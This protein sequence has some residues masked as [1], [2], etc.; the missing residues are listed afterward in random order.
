MYREKTIGIAIPAYQ[1]ENMIFKTLTGIPQ[2][3][4]KI[5]IVDDGSTDKTS[6]EVLRFKKKLGDNRI[7][8]IRNIT[9]RGNG[10]SVVRG[11]KK[12]IR[13]NLD[14]AMIMAGDNQ[15]NPQFITSLLDPV[16]DGECD[17]AK[18]N[19]FIHKKELK[20]M[21]RF[22]YWG[23]IF[24]SLF[25]KLTT[26][27]Y[28]IF[29]SQ[30]SYSATHTATLKKINLNRIAPRYEF[31]NSYLFNLY[32]ANAHIKDIA[33]PAVYENEVSTIRLRHVIPR[34]LWTMFKGFHLRI[35]RKYLSSKL[36]PIG[37]LYAA[38]LTLIMASLIGNIHEYAFYG[39]GSMMLFF[40][41]DSLHEPTSKHLSIKKKNTANND[42]GA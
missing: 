3:I 10:F 33:V 38:G 2:F 25:N 7:I 28:S 11:F 27:Y 8:L 32:M 4:D 21:P 19:R 18:A 15:C 42:S 12:I 13:L 34:T 30:N 40:F 6:E 24:I 20:K 23:N 36:V 35:W 5:V 9:N 41:L 39:I 29:D 16:I 26:G 37:V 1:E 14:I 17:Y 22:R 31:E